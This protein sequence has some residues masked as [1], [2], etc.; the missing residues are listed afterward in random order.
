MARLHDVHTPLPA[1]K[2]E[3][4]AL[5]AALTPAR[6]PGDHARAVM[7]LGATICTPRNP[8]CGICPWRGPCAARAAGTQSAL[9]RK[10]PK[11]ARPTRHGIAWI[12]RRADGAWL[13][14]RRPET[15][16]LGGTLGW[17]G[18]DWTEGPAAGAP[19]AAAPWHEVGEVQH[20]FTHFHLILEIRT[21]D[22]PAG[23]EAERGR[24]VGADAFDPAAL[25]T[26]MRKAHARALPALADRRTG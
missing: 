9:P 22:L 10:A 20:S 4:T 24:F 8:A 23:T 18:T 6:R 17:P 15:G 11:K 1:A 19:P 14:E 5:A 7:D 3:L 21:A 2:P 12:G 16:L 26:L 25:P 13:L